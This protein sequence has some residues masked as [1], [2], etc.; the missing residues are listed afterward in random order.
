MH[1]DNYWGMFYSF[2][3]PVAGPTPFLCPCDVLEPDKVVRIPL[4]KLSQPSYRSGLPALILAC[5][6]KW[7]FP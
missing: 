6:S 7:T 1:G 3:N 2:T 5:L 4:K